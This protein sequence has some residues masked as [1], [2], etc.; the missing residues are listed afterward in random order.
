MSGRTGPLRG[1]RGKKRPRGEPADHALGRSRGG[2]GSHLLLLSDGEGLPLAAELVAGQA[3]ESPYL[4]PVLDGWPLTRSEAG[5]RKWPARLAG[6][7]GMSV[8]RIRA[9]LRERAIE[10]VIPYRSDQLVRMQEAP[11]FDRETYKRRNAIERLVGWL[12]EHRRLATRFEKLALHY[13]A[14]VQLAM[15]RLYSRRLFAYRA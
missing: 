14:M 4:A 5:E 1:R 11:A 10:D 9:W 7:R 3:N 8:P 2:W 6:D 13:L 12:K 15:I